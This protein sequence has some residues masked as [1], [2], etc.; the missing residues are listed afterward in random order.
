M[1]MFGAGGIEVQKGPKWFE[2]INEEPLNMQIIFYYLVQFQI[3]LCSRFDNR[4]QIQIIFLFYMQFHIHLCGRFDIQFD[5]Q[6]L[7]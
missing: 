5:I 3:C 6:I 2:V 1:C 4:L 7:Y